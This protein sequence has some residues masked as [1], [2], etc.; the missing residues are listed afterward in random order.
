MICEWGKS[1]GAG[2]LACAVVG[3]C[4]SP[5]RPEAGDLLISV[6]SSGAYPVVTST[7]PAPQWTVELIGSL[8][9]VATLGDPAPDEFG[10]VSSVVV[11]TDDWIW[12]ADAIN[13]QVKAF[14]PDGSMALEVGRQGEGPGEF[15][16]IYS[17][18]WVDDLLLVLDL[19][20]GR[21]AELSRNGEWLRTRRAPGR[22]SGSPAMLRFYPL[23]DSTVVQWSLKIDDGGATRT[24][25][26]HG[27]SGITG[28]R[29]QL[30]IAPPEVTS[31][32]C[33]RPDGVVSFFNTPF[34]GQQLDHPA[35]AGRTYFAWSREYRIALMEANGDTI[36]VIQR[37]WPVVG[38]SDEEWERETADFRA[39]RDEWPSA[40][41]TPNRMDRPSRKAAIRNLLV[42][43]QG[44]LWVEAVGEH[45]PVWEVFDAEGRLVGSIPGFEYQDRVAPSIRGRR[46][47]WST[48]DSL[49]VQYVHW[50]RVLGDQT[51]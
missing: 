7:G 13:A 34:A 46:I 31:I 24:W 43:T 6:D 51:P 11:G 27:P 20:N 49:G 15:S 33:D 38:I 23:S 25:V 4:Y 5:E 19:G 42:D 1:V 29:Q 37:D 16:S 26:E 22:V 45:G 8:G 28:E 14:R 36:R 3:G 30:A 12:V 18:A 47:A 21:V 41:C 39:L 17:L 35:L 9:E 40:Q 2:M 10:R 50:G 48:A 32:R 44:Q